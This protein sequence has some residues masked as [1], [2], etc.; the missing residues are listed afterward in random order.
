MSFLLQYDAI[1]DSIGC[2]QVEE[3]LVQA[4]DEINLVDKYIGKCWVQNSLLWTTSPSFSPLSNTE[5]EL[6]QDPRTE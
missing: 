3:L 6:W 1:E 5:W 2:G 4:N